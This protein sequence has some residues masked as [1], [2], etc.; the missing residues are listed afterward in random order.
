M[1]SAAE[2]AQVVWLTILHLISAPN[3]VL[4]W[5]RMELLVPVILNFF[6]FLITYL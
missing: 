4:H 1:G 3:T 5:V 2:P 6:F